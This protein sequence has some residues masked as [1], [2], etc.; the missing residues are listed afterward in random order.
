MADNYVGKLLT[1]LTEKT[2]A[3][4]TDLVPVAEKTGTLF[5]MTLAKLKELFLGTKDISGIGDG[6]VKGAIS[7]LNTKIKQGGVRLIQWNQINASTI[8]YA[9]YN[10]ALKI[11]WVNG[12]DAN[13]LP[14]TPQSLSDFWVVLHIPCYVGSNDP[15][16]NDMSYIKQIWMSMVSNEVYTRSYVNSTGWSV[17]SKK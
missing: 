13:M 14:L 7:E 17:F 1:E 15:S 9:D 11:F 4:D 12:W 3:T 8:N 2:T 16:N 5:R 6:T 10:N